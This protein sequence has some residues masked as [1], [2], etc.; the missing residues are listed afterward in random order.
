M[1]DKSNGLNVGYDKFN[2]IS[3]QTN[4]KV[5]HESAQKDQHMRMLMS[6]RLFWF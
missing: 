3:N 1:F 2:R 5:E 6:R 4:N